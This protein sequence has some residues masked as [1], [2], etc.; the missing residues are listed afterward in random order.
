ML[1]DTP[2]PVRPR[3]LERRGRKNE[4]AQKL[5]PKPQVR[6]TARGGEPLAHHIDDRHV[7]EKPAIHTAQRSL[8]RLASASATAGDDAHAH[9]S[10]YGDQTRF[11]RHLPKSLERG[12][13][14]LRLTKRQSKAAHGSS[15]ASPIIENYIQPDCPSHRDSSRSRAQLFKK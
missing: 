14:T 6:R 11:R 4:Y 9:R 2:E 13:S 3:A 5:D 1:S 8:T 10:S 12:L 15:L 7:R